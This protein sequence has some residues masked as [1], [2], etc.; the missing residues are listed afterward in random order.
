[1]DLNLKEFTN[2]ELDILSRRVREEQK[3]RN[4]KRIELIRNF[5]KAWSD[6]EE[7]GISLWTKDSWDEDL[8]LSYDEID[9]V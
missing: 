6:L 5:R 4:N 8:E 9:F 2:E 1:M 7:Y 3:E